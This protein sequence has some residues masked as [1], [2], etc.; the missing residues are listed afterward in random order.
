M[1][2]RDLEKLSDRE[3]LRKLGEDKIFDLFF[4]QIRNLWRVDGLYFLGIEENFGTEAAT[5]IDTKCWE[6]MAILEAKS[7]RR[8]FSIE[9]ETVDLTTLMFLLRNTSWALDHQQNKEIE[10]TSTRGVL[11]IIKCR[12]Q[13]A[14]LRKGLSE[15][16]CKKVRYGYLRNFARTLNPNI[17][18]VCKVCPPDPHPYDLWCEWHFILTES[19]TNP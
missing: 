1:R 12:T 10:V 19:H 5:E 6:T 14:R 7:L 11:R 13:E 3:M 18:V 15:F 9:T 2:K 8:L 16:P 4:L 17:K